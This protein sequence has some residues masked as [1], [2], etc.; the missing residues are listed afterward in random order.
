MLSQRNFFQKFAFA[1][2]DTTIISSIK[3]TPEVKENVRD[4]VECASLL[5]FDL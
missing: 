1:D 3:L 5:W 4:Q 2:F